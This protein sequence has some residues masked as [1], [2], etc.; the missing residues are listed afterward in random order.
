MLCSQEPGD[1][2]L[3]LIGNLDTALR[4]CSQEPGERKLD[5]IGNLDT[6]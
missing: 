5:L 1:R 6:T 2:K 4:L 3:D